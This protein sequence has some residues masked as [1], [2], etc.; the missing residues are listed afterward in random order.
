MSRL[1]RGLYGGWQHSAYVLG[2]VYIGV[3]VSDYLT[4]GIGLLLRMGFL[5]PLRNKL[6]RESST[7]ERAEQGIQ[8]WSKYIGASG[9]LK[10]FLYPHCMHVRHGPALEERPFVHRLPKYPR[11]SQARMWGHV[12]V[13]FKGFLLA[14]EARSVSYRASQG[15]RRQCLQQEQPLGRWGLCL[16]SSQW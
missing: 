7:M 5:K 9:L 14:S 15:C 12:Q 16:Y 13:L 3:V 11:L 8:R 10:R 6:L 1:W 2:L 4:F